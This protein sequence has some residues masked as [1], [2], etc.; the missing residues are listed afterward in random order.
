MF[1]GF[2]D[3]QEFDIV[4]GLY[5]DDSGHYHAEVDRPEDLDYSSEGKEAETI[6]AR[7]HRAGKS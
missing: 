2:L 1:D 3:E 7:R 6:R 4:D 5:R